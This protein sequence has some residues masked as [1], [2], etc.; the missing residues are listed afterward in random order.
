MNVRVI[1]IQSRGLIGRNSEAIL[2]GRIARLNRRF[3][4]VVLMADGGNRQA[5]KM[6]IRGCGRH[7]SARA[8][9][10]A[11]VHVRV[12]RF[13]PGGIFAGFRQVISQC[14]RDQVAGT[15]S[16]RRG[17]IAVCVDVAVARRP[18]RFPFVPQRQ[19]DVELTISTAQF[20]S[21]GNNAPGI[22]ARAARTGD[23]LGFQ[24]SGDGS[25]EQ[26]CEC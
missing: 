12:M 1:P 17:F 22:R 2:K 25:G 15:G 6:K 4:H 26:E 7:Q 5:V 24:R 21:A 14:E 13:G 20:R 19:L 18:V 16:Q 8:S 3:Q 11:G 23:F 10:R 9:V